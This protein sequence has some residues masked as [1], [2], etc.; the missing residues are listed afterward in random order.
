MSRTKSSLERLNSDRSRILAQSDEARALRTAGALLSRGQF[1]MSRSMHVHFI[2][3][4]GTGMAG[5]AGLMASLGHR[6]TGSDRAFDPPMGPAL[7]DY[8][9]ETM[10]GYD[11]KN[12]AGPPD[13]VVVGNVC[14]PDHV[15]AR[16][17]LD[18]GLRCVS[19]PELLESHVLHER[20]S[21]VVAGTHGKTTCTSLLTK[22]LDDAGQQPGFLVGG[23]P[24]DF[25][26]GFRAGTPGGPF[27]IEGDEYDCAFF[28][29]RPKF[30]RYRPEA[31]L[32]T[33]V[34]HD[35]IDIYPDRASY[36]AA[37]EGLIERIPEDGLLVA[38]AGDE[39][40]VR[41]AEKAVCRVVHYATDDDRA[42][43]PAIW[44]GA[45]APPTLGATP[46]E[47]FGGGTFLGRVMMPL[48]G[49]HNARN[50]VGCIALAAEAARADLGGLLKSAARFSGVMR[51]Q[52]LLAVAGG[53]NVVDDF[54]HH[55]TAVRETLR[56]LRGFTKGRLLVAYEPRSATAT[57]ALHQDAYVDA[58]DAADHVWLAPL[59]RAIP[60]DERLDLPA[61]RNAIAE[62]GGS[63]TQHRGQQ[64]LRQRG[65]EHRRH[66][67]A[68]G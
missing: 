37:F 40:V 22:L 64:L 13:L 46:V 26:R 56:G 3:V 17:A 31:V 34:E 27:V 60:E 18:Q 51:R 53:V 47:L 6:V 20:R 35:H 65:C 28:E 39:A 24:Q 25:G 4:A 57:R 63:A 21:F 38:Y 10:R 59:G 55:P 50:L 7:V 23:I 36:E 29:K 44:H 12:L 14:R 9:V 58:F 45:L 49:R 67:H 15:E 61:L 19:F 2:G 66:A 5:V 16:A 32:L 30:W 52:Q 62:R 43:A 68:H 33:S 11:P 54:A 48:A 42:Y 8:G 1:A 41:L